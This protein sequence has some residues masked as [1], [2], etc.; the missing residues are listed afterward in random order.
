MRLLLLLPL[1]LSACAAPEPGNTRII[2]HGGSGTSADLPMNSS[3]ALLGGLH[4]GLSGIEMDVQLTADSVLVAYHDATLGATTSCSGRVNDRTWSELRACPAIYRGKAYPIVRLDSLLAI[5][6]KQ[7]PHAEC[8]FDCKLDTGGDWWSYL[9]A[10]AD[11]LAG[12]HD[13]APTLRINVECQ[14]PEFLHLIAQRRPAMDTYLYATR[15]DP[16]VLDTAMARG[17][18][19]I[20]IA[21]ERITAE[22]VISTQRRGLAVTLF[23]VATVGEHREAF[24]KRP[25]RVQSDTPFEHVR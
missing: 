19:G 4:A 21:N 3:E 10:F 14:L 15:F 18:K 24:S 25:E 1:L 5:I 13:G 11:A 7:Y 12:L 20:T 23:G 16:T 6:A 22:Q 17:C 2:G 8:T 9:H